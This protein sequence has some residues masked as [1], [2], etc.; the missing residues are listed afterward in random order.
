VSVLLFGL[1][2]SY[3][4]AMAARAVGGALNAVI[5]V[6]KAMI[7][8]CRG[9]EGAGGGGQLVLCLLVCVCVCV[10]VWGGG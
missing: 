7:G 3:G 6:E 9:R 5:L 10:C 8:G 4:Q 1:S 2:N